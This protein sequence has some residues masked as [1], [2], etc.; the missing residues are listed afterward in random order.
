MN[1]VI[2]CSGLPASGKSTWTAEQVASS[3]NTIAISKDYLRAML[4]ADSKRKPWHEG[5]VLKVRDAIIDQALKSKRNVII[6]DTNLNPIHEEKIRTLID[7]GQYPEK[8][9]V[10]IQEFDKSLED[11][12]KDDLKRE[13]SVGETVIRDM[14]N[15]YIRPKLKVEQDPKNE[16]AV[17]F[18]L[19]GTLALIDDRNPYDATEC[20]Y[21]KLNQPVYDCLHRY[22][23]GGYKIIICSGRSSKYLKQTD[24]WLGKHGIKP[25]LFLMRKEG[26]VRRDSILKRE[27][28]IK[29]IL[30]KYFVNVVF[31]DRQQVVDTWRDMGLTV[32]QVA[33]GRF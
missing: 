16:D 4:F 13:R 11:C 19:D 2:I 12:I 17:I 15:Q 30:P 27:M 10:R 24:R 1:Q 5:L 20:E 3:P 28:F 6:D 25:D 32:F 29:N 21:D 22:Q 8:V 23:D 33:D 31:D 18:D 7:E 14:H 9:N 26:D